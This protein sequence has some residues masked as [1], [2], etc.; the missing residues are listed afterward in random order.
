M[1]KVLKQKIYWPFLLKLVLMKKQKKEKMLEISEQKN[2]LDDDKKNILKLLRNSDY[3]V[4]SSNFETFGVV[5]IEAMS[6]GLPVISTKSGGP[7]TIIINEKLG[8]LCEKNN[9][10]ALANVIKN[11]TKMNFDSNYIRNYAIRNFSYKFL[12]YNELSRK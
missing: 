9:I 2:N 10:F 3:F 11:I 5:L 6:C 12:S 8:L 1:S 4:L 7:E